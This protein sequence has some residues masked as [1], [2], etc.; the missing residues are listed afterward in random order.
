MGRYLVDGV[1]VEEGVGGGSWKTVLRV[2]KAYVLV[3]LVSV[4]L[5]LSSLSLP[6]EGVLGVG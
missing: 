4:L 2:G 1:V 6:E 3:G 5:D